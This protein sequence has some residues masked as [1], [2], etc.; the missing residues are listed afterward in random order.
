MR[1]YAI[2]TEPRSGST[3]LSRLLRSTGELGNP[4]EYFNPSTVSQVLGVTDYPRAPEQQLA[5]ILRLGA[6]PN[7]VYGLKLFSGEFDAIK[8]ARWPER[9][10]NLAFVHLERQDL[11]GQAISHVRAMQTQQWVADRSPQGEAVYDGDRI[12]AELVRLVRAHTRWRYWFARNG[13]TVLH[14]TYEQMVRAPGDAVGAVAQLVG[15]SGTLKVD[16]GYV[17]RLRPQ[18]DALNEDWRRWFLAEMRDVCSFH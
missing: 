1:G 6:T 5:E 11:L 16:L 8:A 2:C 3:Y 13:L 9:L 4:T 15:V 7:G 12:N 10:P 18:R 17:E 14:L